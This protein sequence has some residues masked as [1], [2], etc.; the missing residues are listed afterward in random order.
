MNFA[1][2]NFEENKGSDSPDS[3]FASNEGIDDTSHEN[4]KGKVSIKNKFCK[5][6]SI[7][8]ACM[9]GNIVKYQQKL[10]GRRSANFKFLYPVL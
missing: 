3:P 9:Y 2:A 10:S 5:K 6:Y 7:A 4:Y 1:A 8:D